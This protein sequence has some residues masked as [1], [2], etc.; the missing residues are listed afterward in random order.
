MIRRA[1]GA[2]GVALALYGGW[3]LVTREDDRLGDVALWLVARRRPARR[4]AGGDRGRPRRAGRPAGARAGAGT[5]R[6]A[7]SC[8]ARSPCSPYRWAAWCPCGQSD[9][10]G[11]R[12]HGRLA[13]ARQDH[14]GGRGRGDART[15]AT[16]LR[17]R[18]DD[19]Q[20]P[21]GRRRPHRARGGRVP[22]A[23]TTR[24][25]R[26]GDGESALR[27]MRPARRPGGARPDAARHRRHRGAPTAG[28]RRH[29]GRHAHRAGWEET[30]P[31][32]ASRS[33]PRLR[34][35]ALPSAPRARPPASTRCCAAPTSRRPHV[36]W[37]TVTWSSTRPRIILRS[38]ERSPT[39]GR[40]FDLLRF[41][42]AHRVPA[43]LARRAAPPGS[44]AGRSEPVHRHRP[45]P[46]AAG[47]GRGRPYAARAAGDGV[48]RGLEAAMTRDQ[49][50]RSCPWPGPRR[51]GGPGRARHR[52]GACGTAP[53][54]GSSG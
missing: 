47:E 5:S 4:G 45:R 17:G 12:L 10:A 42:L 18:G 49:G 39:T 26:G 6:S 28:Q 19:G 40:E 15:L 35:Q 53:S 33:G 3:L 37:S 46:P 16:R 48:G 51:R 9:A 22:P 2:A 25:R 8:S 34:H 7:S 21:G 52:R 14:D 24:G 54:G 29:P 44:R 36:G 1:T 13:G 38:G 20:G 50:C 43:F 31:G 30:G 41:L 27:E 11:P 32:G 23:P